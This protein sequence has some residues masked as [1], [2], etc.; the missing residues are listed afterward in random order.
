MARAGLEIDI[1]ESEYDCETPYRPTKGTCHR[2]ISRGLFNAWRAMIRSALGLV[3]LFLAIA[4]LSLQATEPVPTLDELLKL[5]EKYELPMPPMDAKFVRYELGHEGFDIEGRRVQGFQTFAFL[6]SPRTRTKE[7]VAFDGNFIDEIML[8]TFGMWE[9]KPK[10][11]SLFLLKTWQPQDLIV[12]V[13]AHKLGHRELA[14]Y[15]Y[16]R[17]R[18]IRFNELNMQDPETGIEIKER[19]DRQI[20]DVA[21]HYWSKQMT[22]PNSDRHRVLK[23]LKELIADGQTVDEDD[24]PSIRAYFQSV[25][26]ALVPGKGKPGTPEALID[27][28]VEYSGNFSLLPNDDPRVR[29]IADRGFDAVPALLEHIDDP[30][31]TRAE[32]HSGLSFNPARLTVGDLCGKILQN[33]GAGDIPTDVEKEKREQADRGRIYDRIEKRTGQSVGKLGAMYTKPSI[34]TV[35]RKDAKAWWEKV[36]KTGEKQHALTHIFLPSTIKGVDRTTH[37][38]PLAIVRAKY[39]SGLAALYR[40]ALDESADKL[41]SDIAQAVAES[42]LPVN[43]KRAILE[44]GL[45]HKDCKKRN[46]AFEQL[47]KV[48]RQAFEEKLLSLLEKNPSQNPDEDWKCLGRLPVRFALQAPTP[49]ILKAL[50]KAVARA[51]ADLRLE[52]I[53]AISEEGYDFQ[54]EDKHRLIRVALLSHF[55]DDATICPKAKEGESHSDGIG[56]EYD[57]IEVRN[58]VAIELAAHYRVHVE[59][60]SKRR[61]EEWKVIRERLKREVELELT[62]TILK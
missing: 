17:S 60:D 56:K 45:Q 21:W 14:D 41:H 8:P 12:A 51:P 26:L 44:F 19:P 50:E 2:L 58:Y 10:V 16:T 38:F 57:W 32:A 24:I 62:E 46:A 36:Q 52:L 27:G 37:E 59:N 47:A 15:L 13:Q 20:R 6:I 30:R 25:E 42:S 11:S 31:L 49:K 1:Q 29:E 7:A 61:P 35:S 43:E 39:P 22:M 4:C 33:L 54:V 3:L 5:Y 55:L 28:L 9:I 48:D 40:K 34:A 23:K 53:N 18:K